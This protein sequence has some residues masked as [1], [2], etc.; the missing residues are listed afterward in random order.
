M[1]DMSIIILITNGSI[2]CIHE[3]GWMNLAKVDTHFDRFLDMLVL[4]RQEG[5]EDKLGIWKY[6]FCLNFRLE[7]NLSVSDCPKHLKM[8]QIMDLSSNS[9]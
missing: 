9:S 1:L 5:L 7:T 6:I 8:T 4:R 2:E 3:S